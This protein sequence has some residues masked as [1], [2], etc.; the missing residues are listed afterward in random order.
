MNKTTL[1]SLEE[2][3]ERLEQIDGMYSWAH[4]LYEVREAL[5]EQELYEPEGRCKEC[6]AYNGHLDY[7]SKSAP[8]KRPPNCGTGYCSCIECIYGKDGCVADEEQC[9]DG[10]LARESVIANALKLADEID[11]EFFQGRISN[12][13]GRKAAQMLRMLVEAPVQPVKQETV[14]IPDHIT[15]PFCESNHVPYWLH[16]LKLDA[17]AIRSEALEEAAKV[18]RTAQAKGLQSIR[19]AI[20]AAI[21][22]LK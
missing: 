3:L 14:S 2:A 22:G 8:V 16:D 6:L 19:E 4:L 5:A 13:S 21:R 12:H 17:K 20:E 15:C 1:E 11:A 18:C 9:N 10:C 7:C